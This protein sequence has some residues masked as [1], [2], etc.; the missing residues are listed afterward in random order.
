[1]FAELS[2]RTEGESR[3]VIENNIYSEEKTKA[4]TAAATIRDRVRRNFLRDV[5]RLLAFGG[6]M[7]VDRDRLPRK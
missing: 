5:W 3:C 7:A 2:G 6:C 1:M 4:T